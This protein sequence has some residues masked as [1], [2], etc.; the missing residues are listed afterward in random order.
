MAEDRD[1]KEED[2]DLFQ[3]LTAY[4][5]SARDH[6]GQWREQATEDYGF[7]AGNQWT[8]EDVQHLRKQ[9]RPVIT[10]NR[11]GVI[12]DTIAGLEVGNRQEVHYYPREIGDSGENELLSSAA[13]FFRQESDVEDEESDAFYDS[14]I[15]G[16]GWTET[17]PDYEEDP[18][19]LL[20]TERVD[21]L[22][23][24]WDPQARKRNFSDRRF[25]GYEREFDIHDARDLFP[26]AEDEDLHA[27]WA[28]MTTDPVMAKKEIGPETYTNDKNPDRPAR[29]TVTIV[30]FEWWE[31]ESYF[32]M[33]DPITK[34]RAEIPEGKMAVL[35]DRLAQLGIPAPKPVKLTRK[36]FKH[37]FVGA[38]VLKSGPGRCKDDF[39]LQCITAKRDRNENVPYGVVRAM[40][41]PQR[42]ANKF[43]SQI[44]H[45]INSN[46]K[47]GV[48]AETDAVESVRKFEE[49]WT[50]PSGVTW[51]RPGG[52]GKII[53][54]PPTAFPMGLDRLMQFSISSIRDTTGVSLELL[55]MA[56]RDQPGILESQRK[57][58]GMTI[59]ATLF[60]SLRRYRK[61]Q[62]RVLLYLI[63]NYVPQG[64]LIR[65][66]GETGPRYAPLALDPNSTK[67]DVI[68]DEAATST[69]QK[70]KVWELLV[71]MMP[72]L[73]RQPIPAEVWS[74]LLKFSPLPS[75]L[76]SKIG[77]QLQQAQ[78]QASQQLDPKIM[79]IQAKAQIDQQT[80]Q[81]KMQIAQQEAQGRLAGQAMQ[82]EIEQRKADSELEHADAQFAQDMGQQQAEFIQK[83]A[84][85][86]AEHEQK[87]ALARQQPKGNA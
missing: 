67:Y 40:K 4:Y 18:E 14:I 8:E 61:S 71:Q 45:I 74:E 50:D 30:Y 37:A 24:F 7:V 62:G 17:R 35:K 80:A 82:A 2:I 20:P 47:G 25:C 9:M 49:T 48:I 79:A 56:G 21:P 78:A 42:W 34:Q 85:R 3:R 53:P 39:T 46:A 76:A 22:S 23:C 57:Q 58:A 19:G 72:I 38:K 83:M 15:C 43:F 75:G 28:N 31:R 13:K 41:D 70:E 51:L 65:I 59:L 63:Q 11:V 66:D 27:G 55:G 54:K 52:S 1:D 33:V 64:R 87:M 6:L 77:Q 10:F 86:R 36:V 5:K 73:Q 44:L 29:K 84:Q 26:D 69:N 32:A 60:D 68:V 81:G 16:I 12:V